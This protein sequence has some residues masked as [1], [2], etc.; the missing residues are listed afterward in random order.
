MNAIRRA[1]GL[2]WAAGL[3]LALAAGGLLAGGA[4]AGTLAVSDYD[5]F[6]VVVTDTKGVVTEVS[7]FG[8][9]NG[10]NLLEALRGDAVVE[11]PFRK[12]RSLTVGAY[13]PEKGVSPC[14]VVSSSGKSFEVQIPRL[15]AQ[16]YLGG[17][18]EFGS[19]R[20]RL[21]Q[22][23]RLEFRGPSNPSVTP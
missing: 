16:R 3:A 14:T 2:R 18:S 4:A 17:E 19:F 21:M 7:E 11:I 23:S 15:Q 22:L 10:P 13:V 20:I 9:W 8:F 12:I 1:A 6:E 5:D